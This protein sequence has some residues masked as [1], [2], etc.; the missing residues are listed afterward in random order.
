MRALA[1]ETDNEGI[2]ITGRDTEEKESAEKEIRN[3]N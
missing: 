3:R 2:I 1:S